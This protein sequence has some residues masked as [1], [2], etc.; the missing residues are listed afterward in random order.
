MSSG[1]TLADHVNAEEV[2]RALSTVEGGEVR[3]SGRMLER[4]YTGEGR[5]LVHASE[6]YGNESIGLSEGEALR[7]LNLLVRR[8]DAGLESKKGLLWYYLRV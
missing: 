1:K 2:R 8:G 6:V 4:P 5:P 7:A 3:V